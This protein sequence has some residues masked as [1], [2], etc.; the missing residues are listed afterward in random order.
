MMM[1]DVIPQEFFDGV[2]VPRVVTLDGELLGALD[3]APARA[4]R[5]ALAHP[6][7]PR[8]TRSYGR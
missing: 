8:I 3:D 2:S 7:N 5:P 6:Q 1:I 4:V